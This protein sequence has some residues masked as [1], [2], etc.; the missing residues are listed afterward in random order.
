[1]SRPHRLSPGY[2]GHED[3]GQLTESVRRHPYSVL[4]FDELE[5]AHPTCGAFLL[6]I[7]EDGVLTDAHGKRADFRNTVIV[8]TSNVG[9]E[10]L[11]AGAAQAFPRE[12]PPTRLRPPLSSGNFARSSG[13]SFST[14]WMR[15]SASAPW[16]RER[17]TPLP[18]NSCP[19]SPSAWPPLGWTFPSDQAIRLLAQKGLDPGTAPVP[20]AG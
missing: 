11:S 2:V 9:G 10:R 7:M 20:S 14:G 16:A 19:A 17:W 1:M 8:M 18:G 3:G 15:S 6:Q 13:R 12:R 4:L 5:K